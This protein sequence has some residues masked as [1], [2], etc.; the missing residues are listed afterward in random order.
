LQSTDCKLLIA[1]CPI[2]AIYDLFESEIYNLQSVISNLQFP[3]LRKRMIHCDFK[4][5]RSI[6]C[7]GAHSDDIEIGCGGAIMSLL[8]ERPDIE[9]HWVVFSASGDRAQEAKNSAAELLKQTAKKSIVLHEFRDTCF[10]FVGQEIKECFI[11]L[12]R[13][14]KPDL[15]FTHRR[16]DLHQDH[17]LLAELTWNAFRD[18]AI[19]EYEIPKYDGDLG[20][21]N[22]YAPISEAV[23]QRKV[24][25]LLKYFT[26]QQ[27]KPWFTAST[28]QALLRL[29]GIECNS[30]SGLAEA[31][32]A[33]KLVW[34]PGA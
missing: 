29:R 6:I 5:L 31:F 10:P 23:A 22:F 14:I 3:I 16:D 27:S 28:F 11:K 8:A 9:V 19:L 13:E 20:T 32:Y 1:N 2:R 30:P 33:R 26:S 25:H 21:P 18:Q 12:Q 4:N 17:R 15:I 7:L 34:Q 24:D